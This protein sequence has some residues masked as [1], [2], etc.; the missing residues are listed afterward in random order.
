MAHPTGSKKC[1][2]LIIDPSGQLMEDQATC[3][4]FARIEQSG[5]EI[6]EKKKDVQGL[7]IARQKVQNE[8]GEGLTQFGSLNCIGVKS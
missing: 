6:I 4:A 5:T 7:C 1:Q 3:L 8:S 2:G